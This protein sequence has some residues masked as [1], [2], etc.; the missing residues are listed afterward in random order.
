[1]RS[2]PTASYTT[3]QHRHSI[4][5]HSYTKN[6]AVLS[7]VLLDDNAQAPALQRSMPSCPSSNLP[8]CWLDQQ[9]LAWD[10]SLPPCL[11]LKLPPALCVF[12]ARARTLGMSSSLTATA[13]RAAPAATSGSLAAAAAAPCSMLTAAACM[14]VHRVSTG[15][16]SE[17]REEAER[18]SQRTR[19]TCDDCVLRNALRMCRWQK[20]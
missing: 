8:I 4:V 5:Q 12:Q 10:I 20:A 2:P 17:G 13:S 15:V 1:M 19:P 9:G 11:G 16:G 14:H 18:N 3:M 6:P 7:A